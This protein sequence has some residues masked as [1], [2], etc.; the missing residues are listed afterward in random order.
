MQVIHSKKLIVAFIIILCV[1]LLGFFVIFDL[2]TPAYK[3]DEEYNG[4]LQVAI[5][6]RPRNFFCGP[7]YDIFY[8]GGEWPF[9][10]FK[11]MCSLWRGLAGYAHPR[12]CSLRSP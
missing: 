12:Q 11:P 8:D 1:P 5:G 6:P 9:L 2:T 4:S 7:T 10:V 3:F